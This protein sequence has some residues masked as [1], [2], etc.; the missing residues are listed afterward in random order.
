MNSCPILLVAG[1]DSPWVPDFFFLYVGGYIWDA[2]L[3]VCCFCTGLVLSL[4]LPA[5][6]DVQRLQQLIL[7]LLVS[8]S[9]TCF[10]GYYQLPITNLVQATRASGEVVMQTTPYSCAAASIATIAQ[11]VKPDTPITE[12]DVVKLAG[13]S[14]RGTST[15]AEIHAMQAL[16]LS[17]QYER[18]LSIQDLVNRQQLAVLHVMEPVG[19]IKI[20]HAIV[21]LAID[22]AKQTLL[23]GNPIYGRQV[24]TFTEMQDYWLKEA[25]FVSGSLIKDR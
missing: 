4:E 14:R 16:G 25:V 13:T 3:A 15:L 6:K 22:P 24:K 21:L 2:I 8:L 11:L 5:W 10:L 23:L 19:A 17:P 20:S 9:A 18:N 12:L 1:R 7:F